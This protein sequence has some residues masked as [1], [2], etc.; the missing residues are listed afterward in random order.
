MGRRGGIVATDEPSTEAASRWADAA[1]WKDDELRREAFFFRGGGE[2]LY[3]SLY[4][5]AE[6]TRPVGLVICGSWGVEADRTDPLVR[7]TALAMA[8]LGGAALVFHYPGYGDSFGDL[9]ALDLATL[10]DSAHGAVMQAGER[11][12]GLEWILAG[13]MFGA[14]VVALAQRRAGVDRLLLVQPAL[15]PGAYFQRL[16]A[17]RR[18]LAPGPS[19]REMM[20]AGSAPAMTYGY[21]VPERIAGRAREADAEVAAALAT[22]EGKGAV[23]RQA[24]SPDEEPVPAADRLQRIDVPG[25]WRFGSQNHPQ[26]AAALGEWFDR[27]AR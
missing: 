17:R 5:A 23:V 9:A 26:L 3:G 27:C 19:P 10:S 12:P 14:S 7:S 22:F 18:P 6:L 4:A 15:R 24:S 13:F 1:V 16:R 20:E 11:C 21:P 2:R 8:R 25:T